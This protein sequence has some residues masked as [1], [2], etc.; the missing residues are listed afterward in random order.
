MKHLEF[1]E[2]KGKIVVY[3]H[4]APG[5]PE[6]TSKFEKH[7]TDKNLNIIYFDRFSADRSIKNNEFYQCLASSILKQANDQTIDLI[8][9]STGCHA[10][11]ETSLYLNIAINSMHLISPAAPLNDADFLRNMTGKTLRYLY[12]RQNYRLCSLHGCDLFY[13]HFCF[14]ALSAKTPPSA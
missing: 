12:L 6:G 5:S 2:P 4:R 3:F 10:A 13:S 7:A 11:I 1:G 8:S 14:L 9:F